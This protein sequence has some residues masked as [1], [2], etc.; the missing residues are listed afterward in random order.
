M[1]FPSFI[2]AELYLSFKGNVGDEYKDKGKSIIMNMMRNK[3]LTERLKSGEIQPK[4]LIAMD[5]KDMATKETKERREK[6]EQEAFEA[7]REGSV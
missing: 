7:Y 2:I 5:P 6:A 1:V 4:E 3:V